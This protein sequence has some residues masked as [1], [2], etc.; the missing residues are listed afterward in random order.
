M[1]KRFLSRKITICLLI[2]LTQLSV[3]HDLWSVDRQGKWG[4]AH[5]CGE[6]L[7]SLVLT[8][9]EVINLQSIFNACNGRKNTS[10]DFLRDTA[11]ELESNI[12]HWGCKASLLFSRRQGT[13]GWNGT[14]TKHLTVSS[15]LMVLWAHSAL[16]SQCVLSG[17]QSSGFTVLSGHW[18]FVANESVWQTVLLALALCLIRSL[19]FMEKSIY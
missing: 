15:G 18:D 14:F 12:A 11:C 8:L 5:S 19:I 7:A 6:L 17:F 4:P 9:Q 16:G 13:L 10:A 1:G 3:S 2:P